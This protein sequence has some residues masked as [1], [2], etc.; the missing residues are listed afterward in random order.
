M[1][2]NLN[3]KYQRQIGDSFEAVPILRF[4][5]SQVGRQTCTWAASV[6]WQSDRFCPKSDMARLCGPLVASQKSKRV[7][8]A[9]FGVP[10][11]SVVLGDNHKSHSPPSLLPWLVIKLPVSG[12]TD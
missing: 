5:L 8:I 9:S 10:F 12:E 4:G 1:I 2:L 3:F 6:Q 11:S 7:S